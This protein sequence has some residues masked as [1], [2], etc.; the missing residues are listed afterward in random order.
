MTTSKAS[1]QTWRDKLS[2]RVYDVCEW[3]LFSIHVMDYQKGDALQW[4]IV[5]LDSMMFDEGSIMIL[6]TEWDALYR[7]PIHSVARL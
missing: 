1:L 3:P 6:S 5:S 2:H 4:L 7:N